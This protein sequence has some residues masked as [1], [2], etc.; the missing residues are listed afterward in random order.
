MRQIKF[1]DVIQSE[2]EDRERLD[3]GKDV[4]LH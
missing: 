1:L 3:E 4:E 2:E